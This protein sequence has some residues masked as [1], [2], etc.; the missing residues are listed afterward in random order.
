MLALLDFFFPFLAVHNHL[1]NF[2][3]KPNETLKPIN[4]ADYV[5]P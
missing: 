4:V 5:R 2:S 1:L 3:K